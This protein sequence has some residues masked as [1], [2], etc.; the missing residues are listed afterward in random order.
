MF[1]GSQIGLRWL[2]VREELHICSQ[3]RGGKGLDRQAVVVDST[4]ASVQDSLVT[5]EI[6][7]ALRRCGVSPIVVV[8]SRSQ[9]ATEYRSQG[10]PVRI[11]CH[12]RHQTFPW[13][14][15]LLWRLAGWLSAG[16]QF[17]R[18]YRL[19]RPQVVFVTGDAGWPAVRAATCMRIPCLWYLRELS[20]HWELRSYELFPKRWEGDLILLGRHR[21]RATFLA[22][23]RTVVRDRL[24]EEWLTRTIVLREPVHPRFF[25]HVTVSATEARGRCGLPEIS[26]IVG[27]LLG[28][29]PDRYLKFFVKFAKIVRKFVP[30][31]LFAVLT[32]RG[33]FALRSVERLQGGRALMDCIHV[34]P[35][36][37]DPA[38]FY[39]ACDVVAILDDSSPSGL[40]ALQAMAT[41]R[42]VVAR[43][44]GVYAEVIR[45]GIN[46]LLVRSDE[47]RKFAEKVLVALTREETAKRLATGGREYVLRHY[48]AYR[49]RLRVTR[50]VRDLACM[51][52]RLGS[53]AHEC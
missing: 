8:P 25:R 7:L 35:P 14:R 31:V 47:F 1:A 12:G 41:G 44:Q 27:V 51:N 4:F 50:I 5:S 9:L 20:P 33:E 26:P 16:W 45:P 24:S 39:R 37:S 18:L 15:R 40:P 17:R 3:H 22:S 29:R 13:S 43:R 52:P 48:S 46:G 21:C 32:Q 38:D 53:E 11:I 30:S 34:L 19:L 23:S 6:A 49:F 10:L 28:L 42:P 36:S 2:N